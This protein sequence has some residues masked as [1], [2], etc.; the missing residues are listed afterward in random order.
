MNP[1]STVCIITVFLAVVA[2]ISGQGCRAVAVATSGSFGESEVVKAVS[3]A[4]SVACASVVNGDQCARAAA[5]AI[6][7]A[8]AEA[9]AKAAGPFSQ[10][11]AYAKS[12]ALAVDIETA[13][14]EAASEVFTDGGTVSAA[15]S[16][17]ATATANAI[18]EASATAFALIEADRCKATSACPQNVQVCCFRRGERRTFGNTCEAAT[19][20]FRACSTR[21][22]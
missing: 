16:A 20:G 9:I 10:A 6:A 1:T 17:M 19:A 5:N 8:W 2:P 13:T 21:L 18:A 4:T 7:E 12:Y 11:T 15:A 14:A 3:S 22:C